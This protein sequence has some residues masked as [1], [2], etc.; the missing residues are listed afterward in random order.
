V[1]VHQKHCDFAVTVGVHPA[2][3][4]CREPA[5]GDQLRQ[6]KQIEP[7]FLAYGRGDHWSFQLAQ[8]RS[9]GASWDESAGRMDPGLVQVG[10]VAP[11]RRQDVGT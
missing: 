11:E 5:H 4:R 1:Q 8:Q 9:E 3:E 10:E 7:E 6:R 2:F